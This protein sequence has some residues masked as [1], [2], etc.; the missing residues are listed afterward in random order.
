MGSMSHCFM[1][2]V[3]PAAGGS[4]SA[5]APEV[6]APEVSAPAEVEPENVVPE[7]TYLD[8][9]GPDE[10]VAT[11]SGKSKRKRLGKRVIPFAEVRIGSPSLYW[12]GEE[13]LAGLR[14]TYAD[15]SPLLSCLLIRLDIQAMSFSV[16]GIKG[17][18]PWCNAA[19]TVTSAGRIGVTLTSDVAWHNIG[20]VSSME[21][22]QK[23][24]LDV[25]FLPPRWLTAVPLAF[26]LPSEVRDYENCLR[27]SSG[28]GERLSWLLNEKDLED[29][30]P[31]LKSLIGGGGDEG[32]GAETRSCVDDSKAAVLKWELDYLLTSERDRLT[33]EVYT[34]HIA[35]QDFKE[36]AID[37]AGRAG[38]RIPGVSKAVWVTPWAWCQWISVCM[39]GQ[40]RRVCMHG[41]AGT[42]L[43]AVEA[44]NPEAARTS[45]FDAVRALEDVNF[46]LVNCLKSKNNYID[47]GWNESPRL[48]ILDGPLETSW[49]CSLQP[50]LEQLSVPS[51]FLDDKACWGDFFDLALLNVILVLK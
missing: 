8:L 49:K 9:T 42:P 14:P 40:W 15:K 36:K 51:I 39:E 3:T 2:L 7:D 43:S 27:S 20:Y 6:S 4:S 26:S 21:L 10:V 16:P 19:A 12:Y 13:D 32:G 5:A 37:S 41:V 48:F 17:L 11:Q 29:S 35:F 18:S 44:Y 25:V 38:T 28:A 34:L 1:P 23:L 45:Y 47:A 50:C 24:L 31:R 22:Y 30:P 33:S 46:P